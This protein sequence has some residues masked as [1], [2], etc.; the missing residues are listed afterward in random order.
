M[1]D[2]KITKTKTD[3]DLLSKKKYRKNMEMSLTHW[4]AFLKNYI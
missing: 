3:G 1:L 4:T 2:I